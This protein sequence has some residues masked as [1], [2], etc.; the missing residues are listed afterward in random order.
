LEEVKGG[1]ESESYAAV[2]GVL[3]LDRQPVH[4]L[5]ELVALVEYALIVSA[6]D[7]GARVG[8]EHFAGTTQV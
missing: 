8:G 5:G 3:E 1:R 6:R 4:D 2:A 7:N